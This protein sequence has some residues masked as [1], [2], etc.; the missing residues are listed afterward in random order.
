MF[1]LLEFPVVFAFPL[2]VLYLDRKCV[3]SVWV[4]DG[5]D[6]RQSEISLCTHC[7][8]RALHLLGRP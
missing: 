3:F 6:V 5:P 4:S 1:N 8:R 7:W 2:N